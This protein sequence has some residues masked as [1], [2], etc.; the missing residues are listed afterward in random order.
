MNPVAE[1]LDQG[2]DNIF[3]DLANSTSWEGRIVSIASP[4]ENLRVNQLEVPGRLSI[5]VEPAHPANPQ[6]GTIYFNNTLKK[7]FMFDGTN[8]FDTCCG[9]APTPPPDCVFPNG[10]FQ[11]SAF[12]YEFNGGPI[13]VTQTV[14]QLKIGNRIYLWEPTFEIKLSVFDIDTEIITPIITNNTILFPFGT[15]GSDKIAYSSASN[16]FYFG[17]LLNGPFVNTGNYTGSSAF[18]YKFNLTTQ[19]FDAQIDLPNMSSGDASDINN[20]F[21]KLNMFIY[22]DK[23]W[24]VYVSDTIVKTCSRDLYTLAEIS[25]ATGASI[26]PENRIH[27]SVCVNLLTNNLNLDASNGEIIFPTYIINIGDTGSFYSV[28]VT[29]AEMNVHEYDA[30]ESTDFVP[31][32]VN[33]FPSDT[34]TTFFISDGARGKTYEVEYNTYDV[35]NSYGFFGAAMCEKVVNSKRLVIY[36]TSQETGIL[37]NGLMSFDRVWRVHNITD[38][39][40]ITGSLF[41]SSESTGTLP[42]QIKGFNSEWSLSY[43]SDDTNFIY[44][45]FYTNAVNKICTPYIA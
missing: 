41:I 19:Q 1:I 35:I 8:W 34:G 33:F 22:D 23:L 28:N 18:L 5:P 44:L 9:T 40:P 20:L 32:G 36:K 37:S 30:T 14:S 24:T 25:T 17:T 43:S 29:N 39:N 7:L 2:G 16:S 38:D 10:G 12:I 3:G 42:N 27:P 6:S 31:W 26:F 45:P 4:L 21:G 13:N 11:N 15:K